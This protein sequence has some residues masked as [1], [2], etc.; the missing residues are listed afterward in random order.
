MDDGKKTILRDLFSAQST[1]QQGGTGPDSRPHHHERGVERGVYPMLRACRPLES[2]ERVGYGPGQT[3]PAG[4]CLP[5][6]IPG[7]DI[8]NPAGTYQ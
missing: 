7:A 6:R 3:V 4:Q 5:E 2:I 1:N 8:G